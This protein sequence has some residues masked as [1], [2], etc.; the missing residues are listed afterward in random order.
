MKKSNSVSFLPNILPNNILI[1]KRNR[2]SNKIFMTVSDDLELANIQVEQIND[3]L[4]KDK[5]DIQKLWQKKLTN[6]IYKSSGKRN[7]QLLKEFIQKLKIKKENSLNK[8]DWSKQR[9][10]NKKQVSLI[11]NGNLISKRILEKMEINKRVGDKNIYAKEFVFNTKDISFNNLRR[12]L[13]N[14]EINTI[15]KKEKE[16][17]Q[18]LENERKSLEK[19]IDNFDIYKLDVKQR[20]KED[21]LILNQLIQRNK[22]LYEKNKRLT[23]EYKFIVDE[24]IRY[25]KLIINYKTYASFVHTLLDEDTKILNINLDQYMNYKKWSETDLNTYIKNVLEELDLYLKDILLNE[26]TLNELSEN[27]RLEILF[28][29]MEDNILKV[30]KEKEKLKQELKRMKEENARKYD[31]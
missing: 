3:I 10:L 22:L 14:K 21:E 18:A 17:E 12:K 16:Y 27:N 13:I 20:M 29:I 5:V 1:K 8:F 23:Y 19:D 28:Q 11:I 30:F 9:Y 7:H 2:P 24:I 4:K 15:L 26:N 25:I 31:K 6:N